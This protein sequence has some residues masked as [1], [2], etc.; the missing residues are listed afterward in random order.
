[1]GKRTPGKRQDLMP[2]L[3]SCG[4]PSAQKTRLRVTRSL[5]L[6][7]IQFHRELELARI[8]RSRRLSRVGEERAY[9][10]D[11]V[12]IRDVKHVGD[13][14]HVETLGEMNALGYAEIVEDGKGLHAGVAAKIAVE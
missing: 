9:S 14:I 1:M 4:G 3:E 8:I 7:P 10:R 5:I 6:L 13:Q 11:V 2:K 12:L